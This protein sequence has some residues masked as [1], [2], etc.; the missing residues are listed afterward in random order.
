ML[1]NE[2]DTIFVQSFLDLYPINDK[3]EF[4]DAVA[5]EACEKLEGK[6]KRDNWFTSVY[7]QD[8]V[9]FFKPHMDTVLTEILKDLFPSKLSNQ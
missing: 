2:I 6:S 1:K 5:R 9:W 8:Y 7:E 4:F 3:E